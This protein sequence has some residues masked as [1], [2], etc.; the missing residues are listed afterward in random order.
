MEKNTTIVSKRSF[1]EQSTEKRKKNPQRTETQA[2]TH[3]F[4]ILLFVSK[5]HTIHRWKQNPNNAPFPPIPYEK[6]NTKASS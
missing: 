5:N 3:T 6:Q 2:K 4:P 1:T